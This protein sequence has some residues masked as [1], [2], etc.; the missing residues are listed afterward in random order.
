LQLRRK[1]VG[2][3][4][5]AIKRRVLKVSKPT[6]TKII[7]ISVTLDDPDNAHKLAK[8]LAEQAVALNRKLS[9]GSADDLLKQTRASQQAAALRLK[10]AQEARNEFSKNEPVSSLDSEVSNAGDLKLDIERH[11]SEARAEV[12]DLLAQQQSFHP[13]DGNEAQAQWTAREA[14][15]AQARVATLEGQ[16]RDLSKAMA[17]KASL[18]DQRKERREMLDIELK[19]AH[20]EFESATTK[21]NDIQ[22]SAAFRGERLEI[23]DPGIVPQRPSFPNTPVIV[24]VSFLAA[25]LSALVYLALRFGYL[26]MTR[27][28]AASEYSLR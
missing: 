13:G 12:A 24:L 2:V 1:F 27:F 22:S 18:L 25:L 20:A 14:A 23:M 10:N 6:N 16:H 8:Y 17:E 15:A 28:A 9:D 11:L 19:A 26:R 21:L 7:E 5:E 3:G 4:I